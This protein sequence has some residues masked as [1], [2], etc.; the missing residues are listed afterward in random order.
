MNN[1]NSALL[2]I[3]LVVIVSNLLL[4]VGLEIYR[5]LKDKFKLRKN[6][7]PDDAI[8]QNSIIG[9]VVT[10]LLHFQPEDY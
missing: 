9:W 10:L 3:V 6:Q 8:T 2:I 1:D 5:R 7:R 4:A